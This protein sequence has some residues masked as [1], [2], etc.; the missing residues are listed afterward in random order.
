MDFDLKL[1]GVDDMEKNLNVLGADLAMK[2]FRGALRDAAK[3]LEDY[4]KDHVPVSK[5]ERIVKTKGGSTVTITPGFLKSRIKRRAS[6]NRKGRITKKFGKDDIAII[7]TGVFRVPYV[8]QVEYGTKHNPAAAFIRGAK[9]V[10]PEAINIFV[11]R[12]KRRIQ[13]AERKLA[14]AK[15][16]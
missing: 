7:S 2:T 4:M 1:Y 5:F 14:R 6:S 3:P 12:L 9:N 15:K 16:V 8:V 10:A 13:L 11:L